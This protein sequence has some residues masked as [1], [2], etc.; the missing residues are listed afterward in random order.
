MEKKKVVL[1]LSGGVDSAVA[2]NRLKEQGFE[3]YGVYLDITDEDGVEAAR[4]AASELNIPL[5][6][7]DIRDKL[8]HHVCAPFAA[9]YLAGKTPLPC[10]VCNPTV[11]FPALLEVADRIGA[12]WV[13][14]GHYARTAVGENGRTQ[15][16]RGMHTN[17]QS[18]LLSRLTQEQ[19]QR[20]IFPLSD[21]EKTVTREQA[22]ENH[23]SAADRPDSMEICFVP[24]DDYAAWMAQRGEVPPP[25]DFVDRDGK[26]LGRHKGIY[27]Y[28][29]GQRR[30][31][32]IP[33]EH[34]LFVTD[35][36]PAENQ[37]V[38]S[39]G[40]DL[41][42]STIY[43]TDPNWISIPGFE[44]VLHA[45]ARF[46]HSKNTTDVTVEHDGDGLIV[47][48]DTPVRA[49]TPGQLAVFYHED[50]VLGSAWIERA[51]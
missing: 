45:Q 12:Q 40:D 6:V 16:L 32:G 11:K 44:G 49:P 15:L 9:A 27:H 29:L 3:V 17:D 33:A 4:R 39:S 25:G 41:F 31:L 24:D 37:V 20:V 35:I 50:V 51:F 43:C 21:Y 10:A 1:G 2:A 13:A 18:Y 7:L 14:T 47:R 8:E 34:R 19:L 28:T 22:A 23:L 5:E 36:R 46:R 48:A 30:G 42:Y 26:A 38:L